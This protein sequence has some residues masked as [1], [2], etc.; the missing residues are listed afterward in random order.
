MQG[1]GWWKEQKGVR[2]S[3]GNTKV[4]KENVPAT[5]A[6]IPLQLIEDIE[7]GYFLRKSSS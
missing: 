7:G 3:R 5:G 6:E 2:N 4:R 1:G